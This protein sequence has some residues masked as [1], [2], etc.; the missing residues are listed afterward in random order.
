MVQ[1]ELWVEAGGGWL[2]DVEVALPLDDGTPEGG[3]GGGPGGL[4][5]T[6]SL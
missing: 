2:W 3:P 6:L 1:L 5:W 4:R